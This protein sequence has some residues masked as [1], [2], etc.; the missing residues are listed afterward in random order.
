M[1]DI[2]PRPR[3]QLFLIT[4]SHVEEKILFRDTLLDALDR[5][6]GAASLLIRQRD[7]SVPNIDRVRALATLLIEPLHA[8]NCLVLIEGDPMLAAELG[9]DGVQLQLGA[10]PVDFARKHLG[11][12]ALIGY[13]P[14]LTRH[15]AMLAGETGADYVMFGP[16][17]SSDQ[18]TPRADPD[19]LDIWQETMEL[20][21]VAWGGITPENAAP[22]VQAGADFVAFGEVFFE[23]PD[24]GETLAQFNAL[25]D[26]LAASV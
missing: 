25:F 22:L 8:R 2:P 1:T 17:Y 11:P 13:G 15:D 3:T 4:P 19:T 26:R 12:G 24:W 10:V 16:F 9:A 23:T 14:V 6:G 7:G 21:C 5:S 18:N 20:P